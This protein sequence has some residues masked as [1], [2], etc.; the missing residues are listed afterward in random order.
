MYKEII[1]SSIPFMLVG[2][3]NPLFQSIDQFTFNR[4]MEKAGLAAEALGSLGTT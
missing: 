3:A 2:I 1:M 4:A